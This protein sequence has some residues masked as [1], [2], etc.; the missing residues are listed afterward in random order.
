MNQN[1]PD[2]P[3][4]P[5]PDAEYP[6]VLLVTSKPFEE[7]KQQALE[8][9]EKWD[10]G[11][12]VPRLVNFQDASQLQRVLTPR[13]LELVESLMDA[14]AASIRALA[15]RLDRD[16]RQV[17]DDLDVLSEYRIVQLRPD[18]AAK[19]P[20]V[21][22]ETVRIEVELSVSPDDPTEPGVSV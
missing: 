2:H 7:N 14:P 12:E 5:P 16:V 3:H 8:Y 18:G 9:V 1:S 11:E 20:F 10:D 4:E 13:R 6:S 22:Y 17:H 19:R 15:D 21:P